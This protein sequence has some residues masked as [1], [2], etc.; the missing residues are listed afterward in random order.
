M[1]IIT[2]LDTISFIL[3]SI[4][5]LI[6]GVGIMNTMWIAVRERTQEIGTLRAIGMGRRRVLQ[7]FLLEALVLGLASTLLG[8]L[9][10]A[11]IAYGLDASE[12][13]IP[14]DAVRYILLS[15]RLHLLVEGVDLLKA[16]GSFTLLT[17]IAA[18]GPA[19]RASRLQPVTAIHTIQ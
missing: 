2:G 5:L 14:N 12:I 18:L 1:W 11:M 17:G 7:M 4:L 3:V 8:A 10:G 15:D 16:V 9:V 13:I 6:I 19:L